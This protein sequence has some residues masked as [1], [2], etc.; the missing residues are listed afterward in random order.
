MTSFWS[1]SNRCGPV[2]KPLINIQNLA[3]PSSSGTI[4]FRLGVDNRLGPARAALIDVISGFF[5]WP[6]WTRLAWLEIVQKYRRSMLG[7]FWITAS[8]AIMTISL[9]I[10]YSSLFKTNINEF[11]PYL[12]VG[13]ITW[14]FIGSII[15][16][17]GALFTGA[18]SYITQI[19][20]PFSIY[21]YRFVWTRL[22]IFGHN[23][24]IYLG[25]IAYFRLPLGPA[26]LLAI[27][28]LV[29]FT[30][31]AAFVSTYLGMSSLRF[32]DVPQIINSLFQIVLFVTPIF[33]KP[34]ML[35]ANSR[36]VAF[37][38]FYHLIEV[39]RAPLLGHVPAMESYVAVGLLTVANLLI[40]AFFFVNYRRRITYWI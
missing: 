7:P 20:L 6:L 28:G 39:L 22:I 21:V 9:G 11:I 10:I 36:L 32:R 34:E 27:P 19:R 4:E 12:S 38:P 8:T 15:T 17:A 26:I 33:W 13:L 18:Q 37:N 16:E 23:F 5:Y 24:V 40:A 30:L 25:V 3:E 1:S 29:L 2:D 31:N 14:G 35:G